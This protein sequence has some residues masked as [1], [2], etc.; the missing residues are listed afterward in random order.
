[1]DDGWVHA[2]A[3]FLGLIANE[4]EIAKVQAKC[5]PGVYEVKWPG[6]IRY[7][8]R[9]EYTSIVDQRQVRDMDGKEHMEAIPRALP[10]QTFRI[11]FFVN[12]KLKFKD[13]EKTV[14]KREVPY[15]YVEWPRLF[16]PMCFPD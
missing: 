11:R 9:N 10:G 5:T 3:M 14:M 12:G 7:R 2:Y 6:G 8:K 15:G 16:L 4:N 1:M 13:G